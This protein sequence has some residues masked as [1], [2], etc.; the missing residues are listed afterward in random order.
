MKKKKNRKYEKIIKWIKKTLIWL[1]NWYEQDFLNNHILNLGLFYT[2][3]FGKESFYRS[4]LENW[5]FDLWTVD[6]IYSIF[7]YFSVWMVF[8]SWYLVYYKYYI[9]KQEQTLKKLWYE[10]FLEDEYKVRYEHFLNWLGYFIT[11]IISIVA[12]YIVIISMQ[13][14]FDIANS[15][16]TWKID[17]SG[18]TEMFKKLWTWLWITFAMFISCYLY[19]RWNIISRVN[20]V[21]EKY[22]NLFNK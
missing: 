12:I 11:L 20:Y 17:L 13:T 2:F 18:T 4:Y 9:K 16:I 10:K 19:F 5:K 1:Y 14:S 8:Y 22:Y 3:Y 7:L 6:I 15:S 21:K